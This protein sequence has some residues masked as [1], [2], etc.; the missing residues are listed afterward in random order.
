VPVSPDVSL[1]RFTD[2][3]PSRTVAMFWRPTNVYRDLIPKLAAV[4][5]DTVA[6][7][8]HQEEATA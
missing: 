7:L 6:P 3:V 2:P 4:V 1:R 8:A 5:R